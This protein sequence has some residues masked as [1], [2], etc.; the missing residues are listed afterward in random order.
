[1]QLRSA[2]KALGRQLQRSVREAAGAVE[3]LWTTKA[4]DGSTR[5]CHAH[6][7]E[8][9]VAPTRL[10]D[11]AWLCAAALLE[12]TLL[13]LLP[14]STARVLYSHLTL[15]GTTLRSL[16]RRLLSILLAALPERYRRGFRAT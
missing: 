7:S 14:L 13:A 11:R 1:M 4:P 2:K 6:E 16:G 3:L 9:I 8:R 10:A 15:A 12:H 5:R